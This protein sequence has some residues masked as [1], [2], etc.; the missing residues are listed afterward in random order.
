MGSSPVSRV[1]NADMLCICQHFEKQEI[2][3]FILKTKPKKIRLATPYF[4]ILS[5]HFEAICNL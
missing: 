5:F 4:Y 3:V 2:F 1:S